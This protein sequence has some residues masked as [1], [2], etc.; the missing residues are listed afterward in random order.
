[1]VLTRWSLSRGLMSVR[2][3]IYWLFNAFMRLGISKE[4]MWRSGSWSPAVEIYE[5]NDALILKA[6]LAGV[7]EENVTI[8]IKECALLLRGSRPRESEVNEE[9]YH[10]REWASGAF[11]RYFLLPAI[12][13]QENVTTS[14]RD[15]V[16]KLRLP[17][18]GSATLGRGH[19]EMS[20][21]LS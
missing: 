6:E 16:F 4:E 7:S 17:K 15:G 13:D 19:H 18:A 14:Y 8:E 12:V 20:R 3:A 5:T 21:Q 9:H 2:D 1:M 11:Q 10:C